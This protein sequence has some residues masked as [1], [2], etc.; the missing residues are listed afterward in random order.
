MASYYQSGAPTRT[1]YPAGPGDVPAC[2]E[3]T[4]GGLDGGGVQFVGHGRGQFIQETSYRFVGHGSGD[5]GNQH[6]QLRRNG[7]LSFL[8]TMVCVVV[9]MV[10][11]LA[12]VY[13]FPAR[14]PPQLPA[15]IQSPHTPLMLQVPVP[16]SAAVTAPRSM[17]RREEP[18]QAASGPAQPQQ[19]PTPAASASTRAATAVETTPAVVTRTV[20]PRSTSRPAARAAEPQPS[21]AQCR[22]STDKHTNWGLDQK[23]WCCQHFGL[24]CL[25]A[26]PVQK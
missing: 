19:P 1:M 8:A 22:L 10:G 14:A 6:E 26:P 20:A 24:G 3:S 15:G 25:S 7:V 11:M 23:E 18:K 13:T 17:L 4:C 21:R 9:V 16:P 2:A 5:F 12:C